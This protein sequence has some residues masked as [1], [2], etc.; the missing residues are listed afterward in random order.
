M[1]KRNKLNKSKK[2]KL[3]SISRS[4]LSSGSKSILLNSK[5]S[6]LQVKLEN[7]AKTPKRIDK[8]LIA[9]REAWL[10]S[11]HSSLGHVLSWIASEDPK[12]RGN[13][14]TAFS[15]AVATG[16]YSLW[17][18]NDK[19]LRELANNWRKRQQARPKRKRPL[20]KFPRIKSINP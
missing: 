6:D 13:A 10:Q 11:P 12:Y 9:I 3:L 18:V 2:K 8:T 20:T 4:V 19:E 1:I 17:D 5:Q 15:S 7:E 14:N 16:V